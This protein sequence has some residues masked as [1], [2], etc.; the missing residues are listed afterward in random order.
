MRL[1]LGVLDTDEC[2]WLAG[3]EWTTGSERT[4]VS[5]YGSKTRSWLRREIFLVNGLIIPTTKVRQSIHDLIKRLEL[6]IDILW[7]FYM[8][9]SGWHDK[10]GKMPVMRKLATIQVDSPPVLIQPCSLCEATEN[11]ITW[12]GLLWLWE[13]ILDRMSLSRCSDQVALLSALY[14]KERILK[15]KQ[16][17]QEQ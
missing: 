10:P 2:R 17:D 9:K 13:W 16:P 6:A 8:Y 14:F 7:D 11:L 4:Y 5:P 12:M 15:G 3:P 1:K